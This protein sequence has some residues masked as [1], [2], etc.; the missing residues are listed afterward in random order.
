MLHFW[1]DPRRTFRPAFTDK[2]REFLAFV[3][4]QYIR[5]GVGELDDEKLPHLI[6][7]KYHAV[8]DAATELGP[9]ATIREMFIGFQ[10]HLYEARSV[11]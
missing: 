7:L 2:Q 9:V 8:A 6:D 11:A 4:D 3:L 10:K 5:Q 1:S